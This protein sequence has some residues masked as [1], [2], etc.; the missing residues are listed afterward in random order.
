[1]SGVRIARV[2]AGSWRIDPPAVDFTE[3]DLIGAEKQL[4]ASGAPALAWWRIRNDMHLAG[5]DV[6]QRLREAYRLHALH[7]RLHEGNIE[8]VISAL[9]SAGVDALLLKGW[10]AASMYPERALRPFGDI[11]LWVRPEDRMRAEAELSRHP[12]GAYVDIGN[13]EELKGVPLEDAFGRSRLVRCGAVQVRVLSEEDRLRTLALHLLKHGGWRPTWLCDIAAATESRSAGFDWD[14]CLRGDPPVRDWVGVSIALAG[15]LLGAR[16]GGTPGE[17]RPVP[18]WLLRA[19]LDE[20]DH[21]SPASRGVLLDPLPSPLHRE[22][23][24]G[25]K[26][27]W[28]NPV[29]AT[30]RAGASFGGA[31]R[32]PLQAADILRRLSHKTREFA[33]GG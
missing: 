14:V 26:K 5:T 15:R 12:E 6:G 8:V 16:A 28:P 29:V 18:R 24:G 3:S 9:S 33:R 27:R 11:D 23:V 31:P 30:Y 1:M 10:D 7:A 32:L 22:F 4:M 21:A 25:L 20:W 13:T 2:L 19:I 17:G